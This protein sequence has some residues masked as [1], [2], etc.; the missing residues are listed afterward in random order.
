MSGGGSTDRAKDNVEC[1]VSL[2]SDPPPGD[3]AARQVA[4]DLA[5]DIA[6]EDADD[7]SLGKSIFGA[8]LEVVAGSRIVNEPD[9]D[10]A[11]QGLVGLSIA[12]AV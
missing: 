10:D 12:A 1:Q 6:L 3:L 8:A 9:H 11:P 7:L 2:G 5:G 4:V